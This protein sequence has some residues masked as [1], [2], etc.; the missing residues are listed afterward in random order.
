MSRPDLVI[1]VAHSPHAKGYEELRYALRSACAN[2][3]DLGE[4]W[5][6]G[7]RP[8]WASGINIMPIVQN[9]AKYQNVRRLMR[10]ACESDLVS[11]PFIWSNDDIFFWRPQQLATLELWHGGPLAAYLKKLGRRDSYCNG[12][13]ATVQI[14]QKMGY[15]HPLNWGLH[16]PIL[17]HKAAMQ[18]ALDV[19]GTTPQAIHVRSLYGA[20]QGL[21]GIEKKHDVKISGSSIPSPEWL[22]A[23]SGDIS[24]QQRAIGREVRQ[25]FSEKCRFET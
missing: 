17:V 8:P 2:L 5:V 20:L 25:R 18:R 10:A 16:T 21:E 3:P 11:D 24:F 1:P 13:R 14:L 19:A 15:E 6:L 9:Q 23:S 4:V 12:G 22:Y 7:S